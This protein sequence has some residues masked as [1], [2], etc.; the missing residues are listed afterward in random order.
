MAINQEMF[1]K[2]ANVE[3]YND[4]SRL[5][6]LNQISKLIFGKELNQLNGVG[7]GFMRQAGFGI[8][9]S[10]GHHFGINDAGQNMAILNQAVARSANFRVMDQNGNYSRGTVSG[11]GA[12]TLG[13]A[14]QLNSTAYSMTKS[15]TNARNTHATNGLS[16]TT[17]AQMMGQ[18]VRERGG[19]RTGEYIQAKNVTPGVEGA[20]EAIEKSLAQ[21]ADPKSEQMKRA[22]KA[23]AVAKAVNQVEGWLEH[24]EK[25]K[26]MQKDAQKNTKEVRKRFEKGKAT[27]E[28]MEKAEEEERKVNVRVKA[29]ENIRNEQKA[30][31]EAEKQVKKL[32][33]MEREG[34]ED[35]KKADLEKARAERDRARYASDNAALNEVKKNSKEFK[36]IKVAGKSIGEMDFSNIDSGVIEAVLKGDLDIGSITN[37]LSKELKEGVKATSKNVKELSDIFGTDNFNELQNVAKQLQMGSLTDAKNV[38]EVANRI[39]N[40]KAVAERTGRSVSEVFEEQAAIAQS[41]KDLNGYNADSNVIE[42]LQRVREAAQRNTESGATKL[43]AD[44]QVAKAIDAENIIK[45]ENRRGINV[46]YLMNQNRD[47]LDPEMQKTIAQYDALKQQLNQA[48]TPAERK[49]I[50]KQMERLGISTF[51]ADIVNAETTS[52]AADEDPRSSEFLSGEAE[53][54]TRH[55]DATRF[56]KNIKNS[57]NI[58]KGYEKI[59]GPNWEEQAKKNFGD[60]T[61]TY[62]GDYK[63]LENDR[64]LGKTQRKELEQALEGKSAEEKRKVYKAEQEVEN[65]K[66]KLK[67]AKTDE[68]KTQIKAE[69]EQAEENLDKLGGEK[70]AEARKKNEEEIEKIIEAFKADLD[71]NSNWSEED[72]QRAV[73]AKRRVIE[74]ERST[75]FTR[76][77]ENANI[78]ATIESSKAA[79]SMLSMQQI[80][81]AKM[82]NAD[83]FEKDISGKGEQVSNRSEIQKIVAGVTVG[84]EEINA[85]TAFTAWQ[86]TE[87]QK[88]SGLLTYDEDGKIKVD[89][90]K[91]NEGSRD[92]TAIKENATDAEIDEYAR[93]EKLRKMYG[94][95]SEEEMRE[96]LKNKSKMQQRMMAL[97]DQGK[98]SFRKIGEGDNATYIGVGSEEEDKMVAEQ[99][100]TQKKLNEKTKYLKGMQVDDIKVDPEKGIQ[101]IEING[102]EIKGK[103]AISKAIAKNAASNPEAMQHLREL[104]EKGDERAKTL[105]SQAEGYGTMRASGMKS[106]SKVGD[107]VS[108]MGK[109]FDKKWEDLTP[110]EQAMYGSESNYNLQRVQFAQKYNTMKEE[111]E[112]KD[113]RQE[114]LQIAKD[115]D[116]NWDGK[117]IRSLSPEAMETIARIRGE[118]NKK[119]KENYTAKD[120]L[121]DPEEIKKRAD[122]DGKL[123]I[124]GVG[125]K[126]KDSV[127][128]D[129][130]DAATRATVNAA[131]ELAGNGGLGGDESSVQKGMLS[132]LEALSRCVTPEGRLKITQW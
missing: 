65:L 22:V 28:E 113:A 9:N 41:F 17:V 105:V 23:V 103:A 76:N 31:K 87:T 78:K 125:K 51:G 95:E 44:E 88:G 72:K 11:P 4:P 121:Q 132:S 69:I 90:K 99:Q 63:Q 8:M 16:Q 130:N 85:D 43:T 58:R 14:R 45:R 48:Q 106:Y 35:F 108:V 120:W 100:E 25:L 67:N 122:K 84:N 38:G 89:A 64:K 82:E 2:I 68:E 47:S 29:V 21:G 54:V 73:E 42:K 80:A 7:Q 102:E 24:E 127:T 71:T 49:Q 30:Y 26:D 15:D 115:N 6:L 60:V 13:I 86:D 94:A 74:N 1:D 53:F 81:N 34:H 55:Q 70:Y 117:D 20:E 111:F 93:N 33:E 12:T 123:K 66:D 114:M 92:I 118:N 40:A 129:T 97:Q 56:A 5:A 36:N 96:L 98:A 52:R 119:F 75:N 131:G 62:G 37:K 18:L 91:I 32:E 126:A 27:K 109:N 3:N 116:I 59:Y 57:E 83:Q 39:R 112:N 77:Q 107:M 19:V 128:I 124:Q 110:E 101:S 46:E 79:G 61:T 10:Y 50:L 104:A